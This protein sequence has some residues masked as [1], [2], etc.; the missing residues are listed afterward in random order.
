MASTPEDAQRLFNAAVAALQAGRAD[1]ARRDAGA[2]AA[3]APGNALGTAAARHRL[4]G[5]GR[6]G[7]RGGGGRPA[8]GPGAARGARTDH[9]GRL[10]ARGPATTTALRTITGWR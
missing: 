5:H 8:A 6:R 3:L 10:P 9:E 1:E 4:P 7:G 2:L